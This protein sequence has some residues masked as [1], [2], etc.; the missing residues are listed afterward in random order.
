[1]SCEFY[2]CSGITIFIS[3]IA[4]LVLG[5]NYGEYLNTPELQCYISRVTYPTEIP[6]SSNHQGFVD[7]DCGKR[8]TSDL[9]TCITVYG[10]IIDSDNV[11][12]FNENIIGNDNDD[13]CTFRESSCPNGE[14]ISDRR[15]AVR[16]AIRKAS[17]YIDIKNNNQTIKCYKDQN[18]DDTLYLD[19]DFN[20]DYLF[21]AIGFCSVAILATLYVYIKNKYKYKK[22]KQN[23]NIQVN[24]AFQI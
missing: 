23:K 17:R 21:A 24:S 8:C 3:S 12:I 2:F 4:I 1:M 13:Y 18:N 5:L 20:P 9:G 6:N 19:K 15:E 14:Q 10:Y 16:S 11:K 7:C 22:E